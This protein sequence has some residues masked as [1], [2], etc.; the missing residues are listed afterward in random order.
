MYLFNFISSLYW[1]FSLWSW[2]VVA[3]DVYILFL[4]FLFH[5]SLQLCLFKSSSVIP[6]NFWITWRPFHPLETYWKI[7]NG[8]KFFHSYLLLLI[9]IVDTTWRGTT[10]FVSDNKNNKNGERT[11]VSCWNTTNRSGRKNQI[12]ARHLL[13]VKRNVKTI[14]AGKNI[15]FL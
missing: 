2:Q 12:H 3:N 1:S 14:R 10:L 9:F 5:G 11:H 15:P 8:N 4:R 13:R 6:N 7:L